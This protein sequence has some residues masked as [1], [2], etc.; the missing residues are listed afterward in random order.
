M[1]LKGIMPGEISQRKRQILYDL[2]YTQNL[3]I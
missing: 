2:T 1:D 3:R